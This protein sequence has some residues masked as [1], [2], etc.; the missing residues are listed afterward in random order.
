MTLS[1]AAGGATLEG[2]AT[3]DVEIDDNDAVAIPPPGGGGGGGG[4]ALD[5]VLLALLGLLWLC[6]EFRRGAIRLR[7]G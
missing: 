2:S 3:I 4:G 7:A 6:A 5:L 1:N